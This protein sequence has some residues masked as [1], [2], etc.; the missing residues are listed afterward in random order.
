LGFVGMGW[1]QDQVPRSS[2][3]P[4]SYLTNL[5]ALNWV[6]GPGDYQHFD[7]AY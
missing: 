4:N 5:S 3:Q 2:S 1:G 7:H 6:T